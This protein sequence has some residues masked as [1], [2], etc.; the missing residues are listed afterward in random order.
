MYEIEMLNPFVWL[1]NGALQ[2]I[3]YG[4]G[5]TFWKQG[6]SLSY[7]TIGVIKALRLRANFRQV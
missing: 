7:Q 6:Y 5:A 1:S 3:I 2:T 4:T